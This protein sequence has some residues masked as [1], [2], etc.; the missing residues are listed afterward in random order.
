[1]LQ[2]IIGVFTEAFV[3]HDR[4]TLFVLEESESHRMTYTYESQ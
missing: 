2:T 4:Y 3:S 1:M